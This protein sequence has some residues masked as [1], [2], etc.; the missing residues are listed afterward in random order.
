MPSRNEA[1]ALARTARRRHRLPPYCPPIGRITAADVQRV[2]D[3]GKISYKPASVR[4]M[5]GEVRAVFHHAERSKAIPG[6][7][8]H[9]E[10]IDLPKRPKTPRPVHRPD[11]ADLDDF[12]GVWS[13]SNDG[14]IRLAD[15]LGDDYGLMA[16]IA[17]CLGLRFQEIAGLTVASAEN[18][19]QGEIKVMQALNHQRKLKGPESLAGDRYFVDR[20]LAPDIAAHMTRRGLTRDDSDA[21]RSEECKKEPGSCIWQSNEAPISPRWTWQP[22]LVSFR[23]RCRAGCPC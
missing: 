23:S 7:S 10:D 6:R 19:L 14:L 13:L 11:D 20:D 3:S 9:C 8:S 16:W 5:Y 21:S 22:T 12:V 4:G 17:S 2:V 1:D 18:L 15:G